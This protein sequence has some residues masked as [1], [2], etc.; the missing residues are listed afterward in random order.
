M[1]P[2][3]A[4]DAKPAE[5]AKSEKKVKAEKKASKPC[6]KLTAKNYTRSTNL[7][8]LRTRLLHGRPP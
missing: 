7:R 3:P 6:T 2:K 4:A 5:K 1:A 8:T